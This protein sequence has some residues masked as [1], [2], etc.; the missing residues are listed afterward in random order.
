MTILGAKWPQNAIARWSSVLW[1]AGA[2]S[3]RRNSQNCQRQLRHPRPEALPS[4]VCVRVRWAPTIRPPD[5]Q[6]SA[7]KKTPSQTPH[8]HTHPHPRTPYNAPGTPSPPTMPSQALL[9]LPACAG[10]WGRPPRGSLLL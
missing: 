10:G 9:A 8:H 1:L 3:R 2:T 7:V 6:T 4:V 5:I